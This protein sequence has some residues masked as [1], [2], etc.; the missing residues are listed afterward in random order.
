MIII[1]ID[2]REVENVAIVQEGKGNTLKI[3]LTSNQLIDLIDK[4]I[5]K[6]K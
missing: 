3:A 1:E 4:L 5:A 6:V 2:E